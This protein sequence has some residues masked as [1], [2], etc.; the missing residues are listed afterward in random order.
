MVSV[1]SMLFDPSLYKSLKSHIYC[2]I[3][4]N[5]QQRV[6]LSKLC[7]LKALEGILLKL[8]YWSAQL[9]MMM[10][11]FMNMHDSIWIDLESWSCYPIRLESFPF[12][13]SVD[14]KNSLIDN[15]IIYA[16]L[17]ALGK[18]FCCCLNITPVISV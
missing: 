13:N 7:K 8:Y 4:N 12:I 2:C 15:V 9:K 5:K 18:V 17:L 10:N 3:W 11:W 1:F 6:R 14:Q 16:T